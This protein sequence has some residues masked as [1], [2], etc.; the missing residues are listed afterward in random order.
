MD[1][2]MLRSILDEKFKPIQDD[3][4]DMKDNIKNLQS[5]VK[6]MKTKQSILE[7][8]ID[9]IDDKV[10][11]I[12]PLNVKNH[13]EIAYKLDKLEKDFNFVEI[14]SGKN[15]TDIAMLKSVK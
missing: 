10:S 3:I 14:M 4:K 2:E 5:D 11:E 13:L 1:E 15:F 6:D 7:T 12:E 8:K 9:S